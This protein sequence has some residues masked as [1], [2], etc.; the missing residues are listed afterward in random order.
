MTPTMNALSLLPMH[1]RFLTL[2]AAES[3][4][5]KHHNSRKGL[6]D[7]TTDMDQRVIGKEPQGRKAQSDF[8]EPES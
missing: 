4:N 1:L 2:L 3:V 6:E 5:D 7:I 8:D